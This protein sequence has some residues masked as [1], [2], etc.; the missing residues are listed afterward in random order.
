MRST[1]VPAN[2]R[3]HCLMLI[4]NDSLNQRSSFYGSALFEGG[5]SFNMKNLTELLMWQQG[6]K[7]SGKEKTRGG[8]LHPFWRSKRGSFGSPLILKL[9]VTLLELILL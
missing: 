2:S 4:S 8:R 5:T 9:W 6:T 7:F 1:M 3:L